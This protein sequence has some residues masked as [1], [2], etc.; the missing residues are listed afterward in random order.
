MHTA[1]LIN[2]KISRVGLGVFV[3]SSTHQH[4]PVTMR[5][6][7]K[8]GLLRVCCVHL[9]PRAVP[10][11]GFI[12]VSLS[13]SIVPTRSANRR[14]GV[15]CLSDS[16]SRQSAEISAH[17]ICRNLAAVI[18]KGAGIHIVLGCGSSDG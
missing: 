5:W 18:R 15:N 12:S 3:G 16:R 10:P 7:P 11:R 17:G 8:T 1:A 2:I 14:S 4:G 9:F 13:V 6:N